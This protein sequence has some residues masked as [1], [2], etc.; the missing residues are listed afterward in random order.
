MG[1]LQDALLSEFSSEAE[2]SFSLGDA[3][4]M[5]AN[6][7]LVII[8]FLAAQTA[9]FLNIT[10][11]STARFAQDISAVSISVA[12]I[13]TLSNYCHGIIFS[14]PRATER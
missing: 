1:S 14:F 5:K 6:V 9:Y 13:L 7:L 10:A 8:T 12:A 2:R 4:D 11:G 3:Y